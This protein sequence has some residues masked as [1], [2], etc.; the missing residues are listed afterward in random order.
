MRTNENQT[1]S[2][3]DQY[4][5]VCKTSAMHW[6]AVCLAL[7]TLSPSAQAGMASKAT[8]ATVPCPTAAA[9]MPAPA[10]AVV[11]RKAAVNPSTVT[12]P[13]V[14]LQRPATR[15]VN[16]S[17]VKPK[18][19]PTAAAAP[20]P[21]VGCAPASVVAPPALSTLI[22][23]A[24]PAPAYPSSAL[25]PFAVPLDAVPAVIDGVPDTG[26]PV[27]P[28]AM[29]A[30]ID[31][32]TGARAPVMSSNAPFPWAPALFVGGKPFHPGT[33]GENSWPSLPAQPA[34]PSLPE[35]PR[36]TDREIGLPVPPPGNPDLLPVI[37]SLPEEAGPAEVPEPASLA[38]VLSGL[39]A[40]WAQAVR[41]GRRVRGRLQQRRLQ[42]LA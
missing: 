6:F 18:T 28:Y 39:L 5:S 35:M 17:R 24:S 37:P 14:G 22:T 16:P 9:A 29:P 13:T 38:L 19:A 26:A 42:S 31:D 34:A 30:L 1:L 8:S 11:R 2:S 15:K 25:P 10:R 4:S 12:T 3:V 41:K 33:V 23:G 20:S 7:A 36:E 40:V 32:A 27:A 21:H